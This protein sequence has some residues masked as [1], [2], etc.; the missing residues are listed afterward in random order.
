MVE[1]ILETDAV[2]QKASGEKA[3]L[4]AVAATVT[5]LETTELRSR[6]PLCDAAQ[7]AATESEVSWNG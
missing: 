4:Q 2:E 3:M 6:C 5:L 7:V 1:K